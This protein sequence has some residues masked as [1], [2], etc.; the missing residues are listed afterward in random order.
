M[1]KAFHSAKTSSC[2]KFKHAD[3]LN[4]PPPSEYMLHSMI[5]V[6]LTI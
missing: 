4:P 2:D 5:K 1:H 6:S 3:V